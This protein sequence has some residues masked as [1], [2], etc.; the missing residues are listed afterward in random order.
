MTENPNDHVA[1]RKGMVDDLV[2]KL[3]GPAN[4]ADTGYLRIDPLQQ[5]ATGVLFPQR[6]P[7]AALEDLG[8][9]LH[10]D[11]EDAFEDD[12]E[13][14]M[15]DNSKTSAPAE[16]VSDVAEPLNLANEFSPSA[17]GLSFRLDRGA[18]LIFTVRC[19]TYG[20]ADDPETPGRKGW[21]REPAEQEVKLRIATIGRH[22]PI[23]ISTIRGRLSLRVVTREDTEDKNIVSAMLVNDSP[24]TEGKPKS[25]ECFF[26]A[27]IEVRARSGSRI[28]HQIDRTFGNVGDSELEELDLLFRHRRAFALGHGTATDWNRDERLSM[29]GRTDM[30]RTRALPQYEVKPVRP[31]E[32]SYAKNAAFDFSMGFLFDG[33]GAADPV[34]SITEKLDQLANDYAIWI[35]ER[36]QEEIPKEVSDASAR[37]LGKCRECLDRIR[38]GVDLLRKDPE[39]MLAFRLMNKTMFTQQFHSRLQPRQTDDDFPGEAGDGYGNKWR[40]FQLGFILMNLCSTGDENN[41]ERD[42]VDLIWFP[43]GGGKTEAYLGLAAYAILLRRLRGEGA[44]TTVLMRYTLRLLTSQQFDRASAMILALEMLRQD[45]T[46]G[47]NLGKEPISIGLWVGQS[48]TPNKREQARTKLRELQKDNRASNPFQLLQCPWCRTDLTDLA[49]GYREARNA[50]G[51]RTVVFRCPEPRCRFGGDDANLPVVV[52]DEDIFETPPTLVI[53]TV[54]KFA[55]IAWEDRTRRLFGI[56]TDNAP[57]AL[58]IQDELHLISGPLGTMVGLYEAAIDR[59]CSQGGVRPKIVASTATIRRAGEQCRAL[60]DRKCFE[61]P[62]Q[63]NRAGDSYFAFEDSD[64]PG[65]LYVGFLGNALSSHQTALVR[66]TAPLLQYPNRFDASDDSLAPLIDPYGTLVWYFNT[67]RELGHAATLC[68]GDIPEYLKQ[69]CRQDGIAP[70]DRRMLYDPSELTSRRTAHEIPRILKQLEVPWRRGAKKP[71][72]IDILLATNMIA[73]GVDVPRLGLMLVSGQPKGT[74]EYIQATSRVG[75]EHPG[76][77]VVVYTQTKNRDRSHYERFIAY[78]QSLYRFVE[79]TSVTPFSPQA[80]ERG[81]RG[82]LV[83]LARQLAGFENPSDVGRSRLNGLEVEIDA[84]L[85]RIRSVDGGEYA[86]AEHEID[87]WLKFWK[88]YMPATWGRMGGTVSESTLMYPF[89]AIPD[90]EFQDDAWPVPTSMR[91]V[92]GT[93]TAMVLNTYPDPTETDNAQ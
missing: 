80:R 25:E 40:P 89:G 46:L 4:S 75:R 16:G 3:F 49:K 74:S 66:S 39:A 23:S 38:R 78:H 2:S 47:A 31:R 52:I 32:H 61:F 30:L 7:Q 21:Q 90:P 81:M 84:L 1:F 60:Y 68:V 27:S 70:V 59:L 29:Q 72:P 5:Y 9:T 42:K 36:A 14:N 33:G 85:D 51:D 22:D 82:L 28:F 12:N 6:V 63:G 83:A 20:R 88:K 15:G 44:G 19:A 17:L 58:I 65:R 71:A 93:S 69:L 73:V 55:Q 86:D 91:N 41:P 54:D 8:E 43:T 13:S 92:D 34:T 87:D 45:Q 18:E 64:A 76:L 24:L 48:L 62:P 79:P 56:G 77:V 57:P 35:E 67:L 53:G 11:S 10:E 26:Q 37:N 50:A